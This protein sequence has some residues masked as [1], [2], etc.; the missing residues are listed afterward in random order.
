MSVSGLIFRP[1]C[2]SKMGMAK[3]RFNA[4]SRLRTWTLRAVAAFAFVHREIGRYMFLKNEFVFFNF[5]EPMTFF[6]F[7]YIAIMAIVCSGHFWDA[8]T[9]YRKVF[10]KQKER[11]R[12][13][14]SV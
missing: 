14:A 6:F 2:L 3:K 4:P 7:D 11:T 12:Q 13:C 5:E 10:T 1:K 9:L 8:F